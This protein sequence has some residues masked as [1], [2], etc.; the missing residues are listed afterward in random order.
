MLATIRDDT[1]NMLN[2]QHITPNSKRWD[3]SDIPG[4]SHKQIKGPAHMVEGRHH[5]RNRPPTL[6]TTSVDFYHYPVTVWAYST[7]QP[8]TDVPAPT[9]GRPGEAHQFWAKSYQQFV[10]KCTETAWPISS[11]EIV[12]ILWNI[13]KSSPGLGSALT[14]VS[15]K[16]EINSLSS[17]SGHA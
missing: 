15:T 11:Y 9:G 13:T 8:N 4:G 2:M 5:P 14:N 16:I 7:T 12:E 3:Y 17:L 1:W 10:S 6:G